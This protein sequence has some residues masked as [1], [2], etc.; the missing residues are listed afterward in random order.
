MKAGGQRPLT[1]ALNEELG[2]KHQIRAAGGT[3]AGAAVGV[4]RCPGAERRGTPAQL[5]GSPALVPH[6]WSPT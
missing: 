5:Q 1:V 6:A 2:V 3:Q 4:R